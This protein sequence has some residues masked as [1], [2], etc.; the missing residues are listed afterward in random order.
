M[1]KKAENDEKIVEK[2]ELGCAA[3][4]PRDFEKDVGIFS[5]LLTDDEHALAAEKVIK[6]EKNETKVVSTSGARRVGLISL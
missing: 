5:A 6:R 3:M 2:D 4:I 1:I